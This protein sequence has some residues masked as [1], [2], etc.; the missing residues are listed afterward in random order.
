MNSNP[1]STQLIETPSA[2]DYRNSSS[3]LKS[4]SYHS[5]LLASSRHA[6]SLRS[7]GSI[8]SLENSSIRSDNPAWEDSNT[9]LDSLSQKRKEAELIKR[10][11]I[12]LETKLEN[13]RQKIKLLEAEIR[14]LSKARNDKQN[15]NL[16][17]PRLEILQREIDNKQSEIQMLKEVVDKR[18]NEEEF[19]WKEIDGVKEM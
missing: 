14:E 13:E 17:N 15:R 1:E 19:L 2:R 9:L 12:T 5:Q 6:Y 18:K 4:S 3:L 16:S 11:C 7:S 10:K 8:T